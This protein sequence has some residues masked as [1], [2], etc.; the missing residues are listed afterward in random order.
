MLEWIEAHL[1]VTVKQRVDCWIVVAELEAK[2]SVEILLLMNILG[3]DPTKF[4]S[5]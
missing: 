5:I 3:F 1:L 2:K 4:L